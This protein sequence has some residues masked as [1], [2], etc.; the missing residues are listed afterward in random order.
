VPDA[1]L[2]HHG[3]RDG[4]HDLLDLGGVGHAS[5]AA[6]GADVGGDPL[7]R[8]DGHG[9]G[10]LGDL[11]LVGGGDVHDDAALEHLGQAGLHSEGAGLPLQRRFLLT[12]GSRPDPTW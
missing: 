9:A 6:L 1:G 12:P 4:V 3:D 11:G 8:H 5:H 7:E 2:G 10:V